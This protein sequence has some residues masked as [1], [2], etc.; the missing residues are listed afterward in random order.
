MS[1]GAKAILIAVSIQHVALSLFLFWRF[2]YN[3]RVIPI[4]GPETGFAGTLGRG[5][6]R[7]LIGVQI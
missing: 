7:A 5:N 1:K 3:L 6:N 2:W 4:S